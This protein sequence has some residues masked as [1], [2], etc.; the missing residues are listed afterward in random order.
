M[1]LFIYL[2]TYLPLI[3][4]NLLHFKERR[5]LLD[6]RLRLFIIVFCVVRK[7][8][9]QSKG[10]KKNIASIKIFKNLNLKFFSFKPCAPCAST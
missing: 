1:S 2:I 5:A 6:R 3:T 8:R 4:L 9:E 7:K 10:L